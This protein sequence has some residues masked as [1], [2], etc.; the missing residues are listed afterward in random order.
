MLDPRKEAFNPYLR[1]LADLVSLRDWT[2]GID[3]RPPDCQEGVAEVHLPYG[4]KIA[5]VRLSEEFLDSKP[6]EQR[7]TLA[8]ELIHA[9][10]EPMARM[11]ADHLDGPFLD[12][13]RLQYE[14]A[15]DAIADA[16]APHLP[17]PV[18]VKPAPG[19]D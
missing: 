8:H 16:L 4:R 1:A 10:C 17:L 6:E 7:H 13:F 11:L 12:A 14:Y 2:V 9:H 5:W 3:H 19:E 15:V 18:G